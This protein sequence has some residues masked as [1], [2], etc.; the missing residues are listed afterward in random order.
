MRL[1]LLIVTLGIFVSPSV[2]QHH[3]YIYIQTQPQQPFYVKINNEPLSSN[4]AGFLIIP[5]LIDT[6]HV[7]IMGFPQNAFPEYRFS[8]K[9]LKQDKGF[10]LKN[11]EEKGWGLIDNQ[12]QEIQ[13][14]E[15]VNNEKQDVEYVP[16]PRTNDAFTLILAAVINDPGLPGTDLMSSNNASFA[17]NLPPVEKKQPPKVEEKSTVKKEIPAEVK[18]DTKTTAPP[19]VMDPPETKNS[20]AQ[21]VMNTPENAKNG[22]T[23]KGDKAKP[24]QERYANSTPKQTEPAAVKNPAQPAAGKRSVNKISVF[25]SPSGT[26][27]L[28]ADISENGKAD[29]V[30]VFIPKESE[31]VALEQ[32]KR[33]T[34]KATSTEN[35]QKQ[36]PVISENAA[37]ASQKSTDVVPDSAGKNIPEKT[38][39]VRADCK[40]MATDKDVQL[41]RRKIVAIRETDDMVAAALRDFKAKC[42][43]AEQIKSV[44]IVFIS[45]EGKY[46]LMDAAYPYVYDSFNYSSLESLLSD[47][48]YITR[49]R[50]LLK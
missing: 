23:T 5:K 30:D 10:T 9:G 38:G 40:K 33:V 49:F 20:T 47:T 11:F 6:T 16:A 1:F 44:S 18:P 39:A 50:S 46:K 31:A 14:G 42:Y 13:M 4:T 3:H 26:Q 29:T 24:I 43:T 17:I 32:P 21:V 15:R 8:L 12:T 19:V 7:F 2:A 36:A 28:F 35:L 34:E 27:F 37:I 22:K 25:A 41:L 48:Y 45:D